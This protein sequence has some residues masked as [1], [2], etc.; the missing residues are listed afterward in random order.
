MFNRIAR[1]TARCGTAPTALAVMAIAA[2]AA[3]ALTAIV[4]PLLTGLPASLVLGTTAITAT[5][6]ALPLG[7]VLVKT[8][9]HLDREKGELLAARELLLATNRLGRLGNWQFDLRSGRLV[10][11]QLMH[12][13]LGD[14][15]Q[16]IEPTVPRLFAMIHP[17]DRIAAEAALTRIVED[18]S[19]EA[20]E[21]RVVGLDGVERILWIDGRRLLR[22][23][24]RT[25]GAY[26]ACQDITERKQIRAALRESEDHYR[27]AVELSPQ[28]PW[29]ADPEGNIL[30]AGPRWSKVVGLP[31]DEALGTG[32]MK[33][34]H[35]DDVARTVELWA[36]CLA[37]GESTENEYRLRA[38]DGSYRWF[39]AHAAARRDAEGRVIR[40]YGALE[41]IHDRKTADAA[42]RESEAFVR[43]IL[44]SS[45]EC[46]KVL[47]LEGRVRFINQPGLRLLELDDGAPVLGTV[48]GEGFPE[49]SREIVLDAVET[50]RR[51][52]SVEFTAFCPTAR[53]T[54]KWWEINV[55]PIASKDRQ[56]LRLLAISRD[57]TEAKRAQDALEA[58][59][60]ASETAARRLRTVLESTTD[61]VVTLDHDWRYTFLN[62]GATQVLADG[63][64]LLGQSI[65]EVFPGLN[66]GVSGARLR[67]AALTGSP[68]H[69]EQVAERSGVWFE[70]NAYPTEE[71]LSIF[72]RDVTERRRHQAELTC[73]MEE[74]KAASRAK[75]EFLATMS[76]EIRTPMHGVLG[77]VE[78]LGLTATDDDQ[79]GI[80]AEIRSSGEALLGII[81]D[82]LDFSK[83]EAGRITV[84]TLPTDIRALVEGL[85][86]VFLPDA[87]ARGIGF[88]LEIDPRLEPFH[89]TDAGRL[90]QV[91]TNLV[92]N[93]LKFTE[94]GA[95]TLSVVVEPA[96]PERQRVAISV[97]DTGIGI[98]PE[99][100]ARIFEPFEQADTSTT[101]RFG[102]TGLG[103]AISKRLAAALG[104]DLAV[105]SAPGR[106]S[107][108]TLV[109]TL[110][111]ARQAQEAEP[112]EGALPDIAGTRVLVAE[113]NRVNRLILERILT[114]A[115]C[116]TTFV[117]NG[118]EAVRSAGE[119]DYDIA[120]MDISMPELD[121]YGAARAIR[122]A[123]AAGEAEGFLPIVALTA[124][125][126]E[127]H[128][129]ACRE[130]GIQAMLSKPFRGA[131]ILSAVA[132]YRR[133]PCPGG[134]AVENAPPLLMASGG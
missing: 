76:H 94:D 114:R 116:A 68:V 39:R 71:G 134:A 118:I 60:A 97:I 81:D 126:G 70:V 92:A 1:V 98:A 24:G 100:S 46:V 130:S 84:E 3:C 127:E 128:A 6:V 9:A 72:F 113:D 101:R 13:M 59:K 123:E 107:T 17:E 52:G 8:I 122:T 75:S 5:I 49:E 7:L 51:G 14:P 95:V 63:R 54:E 38:A 67:E 62:P 77:L 119:A 73:K 26:G 10:L 47:D 35:P 29:T 45:T 91:L 32:W 23:D 4:F 66:D 69:Y 125:V 105:E 131:E 112:A 55:T 30:E 132:A 20:A 50:A 58:A 129:A 90:R 103:L 2:A 108:F 80:V 42:L 18:G 78:Q 57:V 41:D 74:A 61:F 96:E 43:S 28:I 12:E 34:L 109:L 22:P 65:W 133:Q 44:E 16:T 37:T 53:G 79:R 88:A 86:R 33:A 115:G 31:N 99:V 87:A 11:S 82:V 64:S 117:E 85:G 48:F 19:S 25:L 27:H 56:P 21:Y 83:L 121:G 15:G 102:G 124:H 89:A 36:R 111:V 106:G 93:A 104:G 120:L 40:W 110:P